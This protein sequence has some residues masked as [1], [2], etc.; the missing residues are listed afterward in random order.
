MEAAAMGSRTLD[1]LRL[2]VVDDHALFCTGLAMM[3]R[4]VPE[5]AEVAVATGVEQAIQVANLLQPDVAIL[6][7][8]MPSYRGFETARLL[9]E[10]S[11]PCRVLFLDDAV[12]H[13]HIR[14]ALRAGALGY[15]TKHA[16]FDEIAAAVLR[17]AAGEAAFCPAAAP[18]FTQAKSG[19]RFDPG[20][21]ATG[22]AKLTPRELEVLVHLAEGL[23]VKRCA[24]RMRLSESTVDNHKCHLMRKLGVHSVVE[25]VRLAGREGLVR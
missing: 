15:W 1:G 22:L 11:V 7:A 17:V 3:F 19:L 2:L 25:L 18:Y 23:S 9:A 20:E 21:A 8:A 5:V 12:N 4:A 13:A 10:S 6:D 14:S 24:E 16:T